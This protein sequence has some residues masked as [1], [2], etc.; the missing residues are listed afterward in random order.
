MHFG[1]ALNLISATITS[2][3]EAEFGTGVSFSHLT[4]SYTFLLLEIELQQHI[5]LQLYLI[6]AI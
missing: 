2:L 4:H 6:Y 1:S 5:H 3:E